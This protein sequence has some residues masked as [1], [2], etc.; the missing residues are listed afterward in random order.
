MRNACTYLLRNCVIISWFIEL[1]NFH[2]VPK[3]KETIMTPLP[4]MSKNT[5][6]KS[7]TFKQIV[8]FLMYRLIYMTCPLPS[9]GNHCHVLFLFKFNFIDAKIFILALH[10]NKDLST[11]LSVKPGDDVASRKASGKRASKKAV[12]IVSCNGW[13]GHLMSNCTE[14]H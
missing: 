10:H 12:V 9:E 5:T 2:I 4:T 8:F 14:C 6:H 13:E 1:W 11:Y 3:L 7:D